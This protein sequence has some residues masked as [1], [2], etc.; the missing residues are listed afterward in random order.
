MAHGSFRFTLLHTDAHCR[1]RRSRFHTPHGAVELPTFMPVATLASVKG[2]QIDAIRATGTQMC[3]A[4]RTIWHCDRAKRSSRTLA[5]PPV[6]GLHG[7]ILTDSGGFKSSASPSAPHHRVAR[8]VPFA[9]RRHELQVS[10][11]RAV[12]IQESLGSDIAMV[13]DHVV[14]LPNESDV[15]REATER[16]V[17]WARRCRDAARREDQALFGIVAGGTRSGVAAMVRRA[18]YRTRHARLRGRGPE[19]GRAAGRNV[20]DSRR[21]RTGPAGRPAALSY[22]ASGVRKTCSKR[23]RRGIDLFDC[24]MPTRNGPPTPWPSPIKG[25]FACGI[26]SISTTIARSKPPAPARHVATDRAYLRH[27]FVS[28]EMLGPILLSLH[29]VTYYQR[30]MT[31]ARQAIVEDRFESFYT[32]KMQGWQSVATTCAKQRGPA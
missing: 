21:H 23:S 10:P 29:N 15:V 27:L 30:L 7:P 5:T 17:R 24:V 32:R 13:L 28:R 9:H 18:A 22:V 25:R 6:H 4:T 2:L 26:S 8:Y 11:E 3:W 14:A 12:E 19:R 20:S 1:A 16:S 31:D